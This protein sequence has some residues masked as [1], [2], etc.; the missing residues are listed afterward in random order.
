[1]LVQSTQKKI[2]LISISLAMGGAERS[3]ALLSQMLSKSGHQVSLVVLN[4]VIVHDYDAE[5]FNLGLYKDGNDRFLKR[6]KR[7]RKLRNYLKKKRFDFII[8]HRPKNNLFKESFY[9]CYLYRGFKVINVYHT[10]NKKMVLTQFPW[11][12]STFLTNNHA[13]VAVSN[14]VK[15]HLLDVYKLPNT[16]TIHNPYVENWPTN[17]SFPELLKNKSYILTYGRIVDLVKDF[18]FL[19]R[20]FNTSKVWESEVYLVI[21]GE[22]PDRQFLETYSESLP[23]SKYVHFLPFSKNPK[24]IV[25]QS[26]CIALT[27][28]FEGFPMVLPEALSLGIPVVSL[29]I[30][31]GP[32]EIVLDGYNGLLVEKRNE[33]MFAEALKKM[34]FDEHFRQECR[35]HARESVKNFS[36]SH[37]TKKWE[38]LLK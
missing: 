11:L 13:N 33:E 20:A 7:F 31:S 4:N 18:S 24:P 25:M 17:E 30:V 8:D 28:K 27:S 15:E 29:D 35:N 9:R 21:M 2:C 22:G 14:Y 37:I 6:L 26:V 34:I 1:M 3:C 10:S 5:L 36:P 12:F 23:C 38:Q 19:L 16:V 32:N